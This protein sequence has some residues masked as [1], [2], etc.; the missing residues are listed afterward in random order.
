MVFDSLLFT[1]PGN[2]GRL[3]CEGHRW[4]ACA[5]SKPVTEAEPGPEDVGA[6]L[7]MFDVKERWFR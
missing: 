1:R 2:L 3:H 6:M 4:P 7:S 5:G